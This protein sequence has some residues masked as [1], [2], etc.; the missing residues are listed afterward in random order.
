MFSASTIYG[1]GFFY[2]YTQNQKE[3]V[4]NR[5]QQ[6]KH[7]SRNR[8]HPLRRA[9]RRDREFARTS[10][11]MSYR[12]TV[13]AAALRW[14]QPAAYSISRRLRRRPRVLHP[15]AASLRGRTAAPSPPP[16]PRGLRPLHRPPCSLTSCSRSHFPHSNTFPPRVDLLRPRTSLLLSRTRAASHVVRRTAAPTRNRKRP[17]ASPLRRSSLSPPPPPRPTHLCSAPRRG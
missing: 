8:C 9:M 17:A 4:P 6:S 3:E 1:N 15:V 13:D 10:T 5:A 11:C 14:E 12:S 7:A 2:L 16:R